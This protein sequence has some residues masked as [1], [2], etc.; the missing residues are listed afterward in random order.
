MSDHDTIVLWG[1]VNIFHTMLQ[2][3]ICQS[4]VRQ[5]EK[6]ILTALSTLPPAKEE[7]ESR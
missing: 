1:M 7:K 5:S 3:C 4:K 6:R 2:V